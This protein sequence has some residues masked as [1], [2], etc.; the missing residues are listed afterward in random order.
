MRGKPR[1]LRSRPADPG[2]YLATMLAAVAKHAVPGTFVE[3]VTLHDDWC[4]F[5]AGR[6]PCDCNPV[7]KTMAEHRHDQ[8]ERN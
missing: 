4:A 5:L 2:N 3:L 7:V 8:A 6:G 1:S